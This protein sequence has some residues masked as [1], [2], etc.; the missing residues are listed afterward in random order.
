MNRE[1]AMVKE[2]HQ[3]F[4]FTINM[5][6]TVISPQLWRVRYNHTLD[7]LSELQI[8]EIHCEQGDSNGLV[9][10]ADALGDILYF[11]YG[12][13]I[14]HGID[15]EPIMAEIHRSN[16]TKERLNPIQY[17][18]AKAVKGDNYSPPNLSSIIKRLAKGK[19]VEKIVTA[20]SE[21]KQG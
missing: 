9:M 14:A 11:V 8:A 3:K 20:K 2:F 7:E 18:D 12:T 6:P 1:Q 21:V 5:K 17:V 4:G 15:M 19:E 16:M 10:V 13:A